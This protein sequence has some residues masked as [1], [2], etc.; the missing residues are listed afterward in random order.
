[1]EMEIQLVQMAITRL[2]PGLNRAKAQAL[3]SAL[4]P[5]KPGLVIF[6]E[7]F[8][9]GFVDEAAIE[10][11]G[12]TSGRNSGRTDPDAW[13]R[14]LA[15][16]LEFFAN[17]A[18]RC[19][20]WI[21]GSSLQP[22]TVGDGQAFRLFNLSIAFDPGGTERARYR[23]IHPFSYGGEDRVFGRG[24][25]TVTLEVDA[26]EDEAGPWRVQ[27]TICYDLRFP[28]LFRAGSSAGAHLITVQANWP[29]ARQLH[30]DT[31]LRARA[32][33]NQAFVAGVN[34][35]GAQETLRFAGGS[36]IISPKGE[37]V[38]QGGADECL[39]GGA[40]QLSNVLGWRKQ[41]PALRD[42]MPWEFFADGS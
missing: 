10:S 23:K 11:S 38:A 19:G 17:L 16:D 37:I 35:C 42:R 2:K 40:I 14:I 30:W 41:F 34:C 4:K 29:E 25:A 12:R 6:P 8:S 9:T 36:A 31:L 27:P 22:D 26:G 32:I 39:V 13:S 33:E 18:R 20:R 7:L 21:F 5:G 24:N 28:E 3:T 15:D 1:M